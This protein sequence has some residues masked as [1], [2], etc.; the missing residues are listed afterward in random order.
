MHNLH[1]YTWKVRQ[2]LKEPCNPQKR[3]KY[4]IGHAP[5]QGQTPRD[6]NQAAKDLN[7]IM[8]RAARN[9]RTTKSSDKHCLLPT[10][11]A[12]IQKNINCPKDSLHKEKAV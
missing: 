12:G 8:H 11:A 4:F 1:K 9:S 6:T 5:Q 3:K 7:A 2:T 10:H